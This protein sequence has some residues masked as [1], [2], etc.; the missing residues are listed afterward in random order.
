MN[1]GTKKFVYK[2]LENSTADKLEVTTGT[3]YEGNIEILSGLIVGDKVVAEGLT[4][5]R[6]GTKIKPMIKSK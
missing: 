5:V 4:K 2:V 1:Q 6:P 3:R